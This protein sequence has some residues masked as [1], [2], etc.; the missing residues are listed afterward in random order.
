[1]SYDGG[2]NLIGIVDAA[3]GLYT[4][5][6]DGSNRMINQ[7]VGPVDTTFTYSGTNGSLTQVDRGL[8]STTAITAAAGQGLGAVNP[9]RSLQSVSVYTD[10]LGNTTTSTLDSLGRVIQVQTADGSAQYWDAGRGRQPDRSTS[11]NWGG[12]RCTYT[13]MTTAH[14]VKT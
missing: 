5:S 11:I 14:S 13:T 8:G 4:F 1:M 12:K 9:I 6:Y 2:N 3:G 7:K 10:A